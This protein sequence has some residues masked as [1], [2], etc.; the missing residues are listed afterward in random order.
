MAQPANPF[1]CLGRDDW[2]NQ[3]WRLKN[4]VAVPII[5]DGAAVRYPKNLQI[6]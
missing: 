2:R 6:D 4:S 5:A 1:S 3:A